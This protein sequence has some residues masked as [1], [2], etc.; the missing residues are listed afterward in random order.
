MIIGLTGTFG[1]GKDTIADYLVENKEFSAV[2]TGDIVREYVKKE[3]WPLTR[4]AQRE[5]ANK[6]RTEKG[7]DFLV[8]EALVRAKRKNKVITG[9]RQANEADF[10]NNTKD[11]ILIAVDAPIK[12][13][14]ERIEKR[15][16]AGDPKT[17]EELQEKENKEMKNK[18]DKN[19]QNISYCMEQAKYTITNDSTFEDLYKKVDDILNKD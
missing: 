5:M 13:R 7:A 14:F 4:D 15:K 1:S 2:A 3:N 6:L 9:I 12:I 19:C 16:R 11:A 17:V 18:G 8:K 10:F